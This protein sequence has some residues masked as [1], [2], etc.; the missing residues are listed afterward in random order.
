MINQDKLNQVIGATLS[1]HP[2]VA[3]RWHNGD[4]TVVA[5]LSAIRDMLV[6]VSTDFEQGLLEPFVKSRPATII[7]D[8]LIKGILPVAKPCFHYVWIKNTANEKITLNAGR[9]LLDNLGRQ[10]RLSSSVSIDGGATVK[11]VCEQSF[12]I[13]QAFKVEA[14]L[15][16]YRHAITL[17]ENDSHVAKINL[18]HVDKKQMVRYTPKFMNAGKGEL[19]YT[20]DSTDFKT[21]NVVFGDDE[22]VGKSVIA[23]ENYR[24]DV[25][26]SDGFIEIGE[27][28]Q[29]ILAE[30]FTK[31]ERGI[32]CYFTNPDD[33]S[34]VG[35]IRQGVN[36]PTLSQLRLLSGYPMAYDDNAVFLGNFDM[37]IRKHYAS[38]FNYMSV[39]NEV[40]HERHYGASLDNI[41]RLNVCVV[42]KQVH[43]QQALENDIA[44][45]IGQADSLFAGRVRFI[46]AQEV[47]Y[48]LNVTG[49]LSGVHDIDEV[50][51]QIKGLLLANY[52]RG[53]LVASRANADG[54]NRQ[55]MVR[56]IYDNVPAFLDRI[57]DFA[58]TTPNH[59]GLK[60]HEWAYLTADSIH[61]DL[62]RSADS[63]NVMWG[64]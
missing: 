16:F 26:Y 60:P 58:I 12:L 64:L 7:A 48:H 39:W 32:K 33:E 28:K 37:L 25:T 6:A 13:S 5:M 44:E 59:G 18:Y 63:G 51:G 29:A 10:W 9:I 36:P 52:G 61:I 19:C 49:S 41:N 47:P 22:R 14:S 27:L 15:P 62:K 54:F 20:V 43:D 50:T 8:A 46:L 24:L 42:A 2:S 11:M 3:R 1:S 38:R 21:L 23:G 17:S 55:E 31:N 56:L 30:L 35:L 4:P 45:C 53:G 34:E 57:S 40:V